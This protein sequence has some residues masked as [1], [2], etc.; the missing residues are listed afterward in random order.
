MSDNNI[1]IN[2]PEIGPYTQLRPFRFW[3][4][5]V[6]PLVYDESLSYYE[7]L[8]KV[9]DYLNKTMEDVDQMITDMGEFKAADTE[10]KTEVRDAY[11][12]FSREVS[13]AVEG[14]ETFVDNYFDNLDVQTEIN[15]KLDAMAAAGY[16]DALF[17]TL[18]TTD[19]INKAGEVT[20]AWIIAN[21]SQEVGYVIDKSLTVD[22]AAADAKVTGDKIDVLNNEIEDAITLISPLYEGETYNGNPVSL[23]ISTPTI[24]SAESEENENII[25][26]G[27]NMFDDSTLLTL[28]TETPHVFNGQGADFTA[29]SPYVLNNPCEGLRFSASMKPDSDLT[30]EMA[31]NILYDDNTTRKEYFY[32]FVADTWLR[33]S[34]SLYS[35]GKTVV[36][37]NIMC[38]RNTASTISVKDIMIEKSNTLTDF[39]PFNGQT[40]TDK[41]VLSKYGINNFIS[42]TLDDVLTVKTLNV[43][44]TLKNKEDIAAI[45]EDLYDIVETSSITVTSNRTVT[46]GSWGVIPLISADVLELLPDFDVDTGSY[47]VTQYKLSGEEQ[48]ITLVKSTTYSKNDTAIFYSV[49]DSDYFV[50]STGEGSLNYRYDAD[51]SFLTKF[52]YISSGKAVDYADSQMAG[53]ITFKNKE[54]TIDKKPYSEK[55]IVFFGDSRTWYDDKAYTPGTKAEWTGRICKGYQKTV[56]QLTG[57]VAINQGYNGYTS[58]QICEKI[59]EY[60]FTDIDAVYLS[61]GVN[62]FIKQDEITTGTLQPIGSV[63]D[64][65]TSYGAWQAAIEYLLTN[66]PALKIYIDTPWVCWNWYG[67]ILPESIAEVKKNVAELYSI[68]CLDLYHISGLN[69]INRDY[70]FV[71]DISGSAQTRLH[72]NDYGNEWLGKIIG[73]YINEY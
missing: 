13:Q 48:T 72:M 68:K 34:I 10:F 54:L 45:N 63:F 38:T 40:M 44:L 43:P 65:T 17:R 28:A 36:S 27:K 22:D 20:S 51:Q 12:A 3:C 37:V 7:L 4:Q 8:C 70:F 23:N 55:T 46:S 25:F 41:Y 71:D 9:V 15:N 49:D 73:K 58:A 24:I 11:I 53:Q 32:N 14:L 35:A 30:M 33:K 69:L 19:I 47:T 59:K 52:S 31:L 60:N 6:L 29:L 61:G 2:T 50:I 67:N 26:C 1:N 5:K 42:N 56:S 66:Y 21:L 39:E 64:E 57:C 18:F 62:D 16:F